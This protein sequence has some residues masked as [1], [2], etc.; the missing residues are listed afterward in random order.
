MGDT[1][2][3][4]GKSPIPRSWQ[5]HARALASRRSLFFSF[6]V[7]RQKPNRGEETPASGRKS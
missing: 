6:L 5:K 2:R 1:R 3:D 7:H 4:D